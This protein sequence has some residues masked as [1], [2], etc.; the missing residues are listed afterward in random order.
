MPRTPALVRRFTSGLRLSAGRNSQ[1]SSSGREFRS[2]S[3]NRL[4]AP[5]VVQNAPAGCDVQIEFGEI[6]G[7]QQERLFAA[8]RTVA[9]RG[10]YFGFHVAPSLVEGV[11]EQG[12]VFVRPLDAVKRRF[13]LIAH[14]HAFPCHLPPRS[15]SIN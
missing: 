1:I 10:G 8:L 11:G 13:G 12:H 7:N 3:S 6:I 14:R 9:F 4:R 15:G 5:Q 2:A